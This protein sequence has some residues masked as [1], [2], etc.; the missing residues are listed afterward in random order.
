MLILF[1]ARTFA[2]PDHLN[3]LDTSVFREMALWALLSTRFVPSQSIF[4][5][6][7]SA[8]VTSD[9]NHEDCLMKIAGNFGWMS[10]EN[11]LVLRFATSILQISSVNHHQCLGNL[12]I[13][14]NCPR[15]LCTI[16]HCWCRVVQKLDN[17]HLSTNHRLGKPR[18]KNRTFIFKF[19]FFS[20]RFRGYR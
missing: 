10:L 1:S 9:S 7:Y 13:I 16:P 8:I 14:S 2:P 19:K 11:S 5:V 12:C 4:P 15:H 20:Y 17:P 3:S 18:R 6:N